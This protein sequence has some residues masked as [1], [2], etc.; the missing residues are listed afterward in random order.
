MR[1]RCPDALGENLD[2]T[3]LTMGKTGGGNGQGTLVHETAA[4]G[5]EENTPTLCGIRLSQ[6]S[7]CSSCSLTSDCTA[8][9]KR[10]DS[11]QVLL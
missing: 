7:A 5:P 1:K 11:L 3:K 4:W 9:S 8:Q 10:Q 6:S 2:T